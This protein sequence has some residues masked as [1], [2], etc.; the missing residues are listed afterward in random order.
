MS[1]HEISEDQSTFYYQLTGFV[2]LSGDQFNSIL[3]AKTY[4]TSNTA[5]LAMLAFK[6]DLTHLHSNQPNLSPASVSS[7]DHYKSRYGGMYCGVIRLVF[8]GSIPTRS[9]FHSAN[10][11]VTCSCCFF[12]FVGVFFMGRCMICNIQKYR[13]LLFTKNKVS[14]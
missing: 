14:S 3:Q 7:T 10:F 6:K 5:T 8:E 12:C 2:D 1:Q 13:T 11:F 9:C 4:L